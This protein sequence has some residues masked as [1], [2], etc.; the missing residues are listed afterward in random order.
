MVGHAVPG[1][2]A[3]TAPV[4]AG[5]DATAAA[6]RYAHA[7]GKLQTKI[8]SLHDIRNTIP[9]GAEYDRARAATNYAI[10]QTTR[11]LNGYYEATM[12]TV[13]GAAVGQSGWIRI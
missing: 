11:Q 1:A 9:P 6:A 5:V 12:N 8:D 10:S 3:I 7:Y 2:A 4:A 13:G